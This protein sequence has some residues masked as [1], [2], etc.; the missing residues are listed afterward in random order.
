[1]ENQNLESQEVSVIETALSKQ[2][3][4]AQVIAKLKADYSGLTINGI[5]DKDGFNRVEMAR[6]ECKAVRVLASK[7]CV[8]GREK[9]IK[10][11]KDWIAKEKEVVAEI[12]EIE[13]YLEKE[14]DRIKEEKE[15]ILFEAVQL[16]K[17]PARK[18]KL[19]T[20][21]VSV[22]DSELLKIDD[23]KFDLLCWE[24]YV[25]HLEEKAE[26]LRLEEEKKRK[27]LEEKAE[28]ERI[29]AKK[30]A[31]AKAEDQRLENERLKAEAEAKELELQK[32]REDAEKREAEL[33]AKADAELLEQKRLAEI[34][35]K[36]Q[37][38][39]IAK[40][41]EESDRL[42][43]ELKAKADA[44]AKALAE[45]IE[46][47]RLALI[48]EKQAA[49]APDKEKLLIWIE[50]LELPFVELKQN[51]SNILAS[52]LKVKLSSYKK[53]AKSEIEKLK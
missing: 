23:V 33:K 48:T 12:S 39:I 29:E 35:A 15:R 41:K 42:A 49:K 43:A 6:K 21:G 19:M 2:N 46:S 14:S 10:E 16:Q 7:I 45:K 4:T 37:A 51:E 3:V 38:D 1:M 34:E 11:Q 32:E 22:E 52:D 18:D 28:A 13:N 50:S 53:W 30:I 47:E 27:E 9:A 36:K 25:K 5:D 17:L 8:A 44:E 20:L 40:Q 26:A 31:E 24:F